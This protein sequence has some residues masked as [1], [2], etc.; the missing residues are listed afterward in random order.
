MGDGKRRKRAAI[1]ASK[2]LAAWKLC[3]FSDDDCVA[4]YVNAN[5]GSEEAT[6]MVFASIYM[7]FDSPTPP[8]S[9]KFT[10]LVNFCQERD[11][12]LIIG[13]DANSHHPQWGSSN[14]NS[15]GDALFAY[16]LS[17]PL[18]I[19]NTGHK[20]T[21]ITKNRR[22]VLD[23]TFASDRAYD[24]VVNWRVED[25]ETQSDHRLIRFDIEGSWKKE[26][27]RYRNVK[28]TDWTK[29]Q[30][31]LIT[32]LENW[33]APEISSVEEIEEAC[34][35]VQAEIIRSFEIS[36]RLT[37]RRRRK[38]PPWWHQGLNS[39]HREV[40]RLK[41][42]YLRNPTDENKEAK[43]QAQKAFKRELR[44]SKR[45]V[46][47]TYCSSIDAL[48]A[49]ARLHAIL[50][51][52]L[53]VQQGTLKR[54]DGS[55]TATPEESVDLLLE[56][57]FPD[58]PEGE[59]PWQPDII[60]GA[61]GESL[62]WEIVTEGRLE[63]ALLSFSP[64]KASGPD[65]IKPI[66]L[67]KGLQ[68]LKGPITAIYRACLTYGH[69]PTLWRKTNVVFLSKPGKE[70]YSSPKSY[71][72]ISLSSFL[73]K[74]LERL[75]LW[76]LVDTV[77]GREIFHNRQFAYR[78]GRTSID[79][80][81]TL[82]M[83]LE[84]A[85]YSK[86]VAIGVF[87]DIEGAFNNARTSSM[88]NALQ[89]R[90]APPTIIRWV[91]VMLT[92]RTAMTNLRGC[93]R[94]RRVMM[95]TPQ[96]GIL[97][98]VLW[99]LVMDTLLEVNNAGLGTTTQAFADDV[100]PIGIGP[101]IYT[102]GNILQ[103]TLRWLE[104]WATTHKLRFCARKSVA[105]LFTWKR[106]KPI[107]LF[108]NG[109]KLVFKKQ[110]KYLGITLDARL[111]WTP[112]VR[113][114]TRKA[115]ISLAQCRRAV[116]LSWGLQPHVML[117]IYKAIIRPMIEYGCVIWSASL[118]LDIVQTLLSKV[119]R[120]ACLCITSAYP[121]TPSAVLGAMLDLPP[122]HAYLQGAALKTAHRMKLN[123]Q[124]MGTKRHVGSTKSHVDFCN[125]LLRS[126]EVFSLPVDR[127]TVVRKFNHGYKVTIPD[128]DW[129]TA[130]GSRMVPGSRE[131]IFCFTDGSK[132]NHGTGS[133]YIIRSTNLSKDGRKTLDD[134]SSVFQAEIMAISET[135]DWL[136]SE[137]TRWKNVTIYS[138]SQAALKAL[139]GYRFTSNLT[140]E[141]SNKLSKLARVNRVSLQWIPSHTGYEGNEAADALAKEATERS[142]LGPTP[143][144]PIPP[145][146]VSGMVD[147]LVRGAHLDTWR[148]R[149]D[150]RQAKLFG[151][152]PHPRRALHFLSMSRSS[153]RDVIQIV[154]GHGNFAKH[155]FACGKINSP[156]CRWCDGVEETAFHHMAE[157]SRYDL[158]RLCIFGRN[159]LA[160]ED[161][162]GLP[163]QSVVSYVKATLRLKD[164]GP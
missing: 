164:F 26:Q 128:R 132:T 11:W 71:R 22:E 6:P 80:V 89:N 35:I 73:L 93:D 129:Y 118:K 43:I 68:M 31:E 133:G 46:W 19:C 83:E 86:Q 30:E 24:L 5:L 9:E 96:G 48:P 109:E 147:E 17:S 4:V 158:A 99:N 134:L 3:Q 124:W 42:R 78:T 107:N 88:V 63:A 161:L 65:N 85:V 139:Q 8:P 137:E 23:V 84:K 60:V 10:A 28:N 97:S 115:T 18:M 100:V 90:G 33:Q 39:L 29:Y 113:A 160:E 66:L 92:K 108:L 47:A 2:T 127:R 50:K 153:L 12:R 130:A 116:G 37:E 27:V 111:S 49:A 123:G 52:N 69:V 142:P 125:T 38:T 57:H 53:T 144:I 54:P 91:Y 135:A 25:R 143:I 149:E 72:P 81:H 114:V 79:G 155:R 56:T 145:K 70:D 7:P 159:K 163:I 14:V 150:C 67:Q 20:P 112:H 32:R 104:R 40:S 13:C 146:V 95:G 77:L 138:D 76:H 44:R 117:W 106:V 51:R 102:V 1:I 119:Q 98:P 94:Q 41:R 151:L 64:Y 87:L 136:I 34:Q 62:H 141:C 162:P 58:T 152:K 55:F 120:L 121:S 59:E 16:V 101:D 21:F 148:N 61:Q 154:S 105:V 131:E 110:V 74:G 126:S 122:L 75:I 15:R 82:V 140:L 36:C 156:L 157:C 103:R 45:E